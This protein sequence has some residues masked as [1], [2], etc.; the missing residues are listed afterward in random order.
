MKGIPARTQGIVASGLM[1]ILV[2]G[3]FANLTFTG[4]ES[5]IYEL[6]YGILTAN[7][8]TVKGT[9]LQSTESGPARQLLGFVERLLAAGATYNVQNVDSRGREAAVVVIYTSPRFGVFGVQYS[10]YKSRDRWLVDADKT[11]GALAARG[12]N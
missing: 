8:E 10:L 3:V 6:H 4:P 1:A 9:V 5:T 12:T 11:L 2:L 7:R